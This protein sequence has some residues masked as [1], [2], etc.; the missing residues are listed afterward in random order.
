MTCPIGCG[1]VYSKY[2][3]VIYI[4]IIDYLIEIIISLDNL[5]DNFNF[6]LFNVPELKNHTLIKNLF[7]FLGFII[8]GLI[9]FYIFIIKNNKKEQNL[10]ENMKKQKVN[11]GL[12]HNKKIKIQV[13]N[14][15]I[16][17]LIVSLFF[18][19]FYEIDKIFYS[20]GFYDL[21]LWGFN[22]I[23]TIFF[24][25]IYFTLDQY[26]HQLYSLIFVFFV[27]LIFLIIS[28]FLPL[29]KD[30]PINSYDYI[31]ELFKEQLFCIPIYLIFIL[32]SYLIS[33][34]RVKSKVLMEF[35]YISPYKIIILIGFS[36]LL[37]TSILLTITS[38]FKCEGRIIKICDVKYKDGDNNLDKYYDN[39][40]VYFSNLKKSETVEF[41]IEIILII[42]LF[43]FLNF[44]KILVEMLTI[45]YLN[46]FCV[47]F[48]NNL[49]Y[50]TRNIFSFIFNYNK[51]NPLNIKKYILKAISNFLCIFAYFIY[52]E[53]IECR[54]C[55]LN[56]NLKK[57]LLERSKNEI[58]ISDESLYDDNINEDNDESN[59]HLEISNIFDL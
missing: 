58:N 34:S 17:I 51:S 19:I 33:F 41:W 5:K 43:S 55:G 20:L 44:M 57:S 21:D 38:I 4:V 28:S 15:T 13:S 45:F 22:I 26:S 47:L 11:S 39:L 23:F 53:M 24:I 40:L 56:K 14:S 30:E 7:L 2:L 16:E 36:G 3:Y 35:N 52:L 6:S 31:A 49:Y 29:K 1:K 12:I 50:G 10:I 46:P 8:F 32:N 27:N 37:I 18:S 59:S 9:F 54:F 48:S 25:K 42:P